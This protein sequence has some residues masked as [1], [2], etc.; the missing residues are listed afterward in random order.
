MHHAHHDDKRQVERIATER[1]VKL[2]I[3]D[4]IVQGKMIDLSILGAGVL[5]NKTCRKEDIIELEF[6]LPSMGAKSLKM[7][8]KVVHL[9]S[10]RGNCLMGLRFDPEKNS[11]Q[12]AISEF[13]RY[14]N[15]QII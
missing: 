3:S 14:H 12:V 11:D 4:E 13:I 8:A 7:G 5:S 6:Q 10:V 9:A 15:R 1:P 2:Y